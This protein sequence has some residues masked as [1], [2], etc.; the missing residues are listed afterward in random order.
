[1]VRWVVSRDRGSSD[2]EQRLCDACPSQLVI[3]DLEFGIGSRD[4]GIGVIRYGQAWMVQH[5]M[6]RQGMVRMVFTWLVF[7]RLA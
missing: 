3:S 4:W 2:V 5:S 6:V 1:V 7:T